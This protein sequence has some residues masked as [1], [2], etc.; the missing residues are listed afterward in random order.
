MNEQIYKDAYTCLIIETGC[1]RNWLLL[2]YLR[3]KPLEQCGEQNMN[4][5]DF[6]IPTGVFLWWSD[7]SSSSTLKNIS[8]YYIPFILSDNGNVVNSPF[9]CTMIIL[10]N[11]FER[12]T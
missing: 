1:L 3:M 5:I 8:S 2:G 12:V 9:S 10:I 6:S 7:K 4:R 11:K